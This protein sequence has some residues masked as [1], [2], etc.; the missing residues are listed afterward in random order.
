MSLTAVALWLRQRGLQVLFALALAWL[1]LVLMWES[2]DW[3]DLGRED[4]DLY[5]KTG[6]ATALLVV[7][8]VCRRWSDFMSLPPSI[9][10]FSVVG[11]FAQAFVISIVLVPSFFGLWAWYFDYDPSSTNPQADMVVISAAY[12]YGVFFTP[13]VTVI[14]AWYLLR[15]RSERYEL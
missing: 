2:A 9:S 12:W 4:A 13:I 6:C 3:L 8:L 7:F 14:L 15:D 10:F 11:R 1:T 5:I